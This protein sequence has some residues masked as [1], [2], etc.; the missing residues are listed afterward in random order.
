MHSLEQVLRNRRLL[1][2]HPGDLV[3]DVIQRMTAARVGAVTILDGEHLVGVRGVPE[4]GE[5][6][7]AV[8]RATQAGLN[9]SEAGVHEEHEHAS[10]QDPHRVH[11]DT[12][13]AQSSCVDC[14]CCRCG[15]VVSIYG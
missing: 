3:L 9:E 5:D 15:R 4:V 8:L 13:A 11:A 12:Q 6:V 10:H 7:H 14:R 1:T 2:A